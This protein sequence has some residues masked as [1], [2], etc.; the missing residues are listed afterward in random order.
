MRLATLL[1]AVVVLSPLASAQHNHEAPETGE[2]TSYVVT[3]LRIDEADPPRG[4][5]VGRAGA[6]LSG[7][8]YVHVVYGK[9]YTRGR[10]IFGGVVGMDTIWTPGAHNATEL[11]STVPFSF[12]GT[13]LAAGAYSVFVMPKEDVW[14]I[15]LNATLGMH[16]ADEY[17]PAHDVASVDV[18]TETLSEVVQGLTIDF[19]PA[20]TGADFRIR[21]DRTSATVPIRVD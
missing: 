18:R 12:G 2:T 16:L 4:S 10:L 19:V 11:F 7:G 15:H 17:D 5:G 3:G 20:G 13:R 14:T 6:R 9:P 1:A 21:W 8:G